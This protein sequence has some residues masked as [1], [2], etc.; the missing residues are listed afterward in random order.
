M[1]PNMVEAL[2]SA[3]AETHR[4]N[5]QH[6]THSD[7]LLTPTGVSGDH[8]APV[9]KHVGLEILSLMEDSND[10]GYAMWLSTVVVK[11]PAQ[12]DKSKNNNATRTIVARISAFTTSRHR[13]G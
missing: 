9:A 5:Q 13:A 7:V 2:L 10:K 3:Q 4:V 1:L 6:A 8:G 11:Q 12:Q